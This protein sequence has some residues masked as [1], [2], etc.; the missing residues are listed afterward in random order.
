MRALGIA[1]V[2]YVVAFFVLLDVRYP[3]TCHAEKSR[4]DPRPVSVGPLPNG[5]WPIF[6]LCPPPWSNGYYNGGEWEFRVFW[7]LCRLWLWVNGYVPPDEMEVG[8]TP[9]SDASH[10]L[11]RSVDGSRA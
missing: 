6:L 1:L 11:P 8:G 10:A 7:P 2:I 3:A 4:Y 5:V 9:S